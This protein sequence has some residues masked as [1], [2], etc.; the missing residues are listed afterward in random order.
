MVESHTVSAIA[1]VNM[2]LL[3]ARYWPLSPEDVYNPVSTHAL[4]T[5]DNIKEV[6][7]AVSRPINR[8]QQSLI[9]PQPEVFAPSPE[10]AQF[11]RAVNALPSDCF[12]PSLNRPHGVYSTVPPPLA[13]A[14][15][16]RV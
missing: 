14:S 3:N 7:T 12:D 9:R 15:S 13:N 5:V 11:G 10:V 6:V 2:N 4:F 1:A 8:C 16:R